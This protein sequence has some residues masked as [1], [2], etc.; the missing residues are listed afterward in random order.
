[1]I[2]VASLPFAAFFIR[3][4]SAASAFDALALLSVA[5][6]LRC[7]LDPVDNAY[8]H[9]PLVLAVLAWETLARPRRLPIV[10][11]LTAAALWL[12][13][14][15]VEPTMSAASANAFYLSW[16]A[17]LFA[18]LLYELRLL[19]SIGRSAAVQTA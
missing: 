10:S 7:V 16:T 18:Y 13:F 19:P 2:V 17:A 15:H 8:Y 11:L 9:V 12:T 5:F 1:L 3:R 4:R 14:D 6:L